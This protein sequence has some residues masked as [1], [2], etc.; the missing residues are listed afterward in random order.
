[1]STGSVIGSILVLLHFYAWNPAVASLWPG[2]AGVFQVILILGSAL[3][4]FVSRTQG[5]ADAYGGYSGF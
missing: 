3:L 4:F 1:M 2:V 5:T